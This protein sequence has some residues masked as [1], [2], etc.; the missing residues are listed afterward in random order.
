MNEPQYNSQQNHI[1]NSDPFYEFDSKSSNLV[2]ELESIQQ[3]LAENPPL[4]RGDNSNDSILKK[5]RF[6]FI[7]LMC[8]SAIALFIA[9]FQILVSVPPVHFPLEAPKPSP[10]AP[11][12]IPAARPRT[13]EEVDHAI[14]TL[15]NYVNQAKWASEETAKKSLNDVKS[16]LE[17]QAKAAN[18]IRL[19]TIFSSGLF[20]IALA[21]GA[22][23]VRISQNPNQSAIDK[24]EIDQIKIA[25]ENSILKFIDLVKLFQ[26]IY[27]TAYSNKK[28]S[29]NQIET[30]KS[31]FDLLNSQTELIAKGNDSFSKDAVI[32]YVQTSSETIQSQIADLERK[33]NECL[34]KMTEIDGQLANT[35][36]LINSFSSNLDRFTREIVNA[37]PQAEPLDYDYVKTRL[38][39]LREDIN[40]FDE[41]PRLKSNAENALSLLHDA[42]K[43]IGALDEK[44]ISQILVPFNLS[45]Y[46]L[47]IEKWSKAGKIAQELEVLR[48]STIANLKRKFEKQ[49]RIIDPE[50]STF[51]DAVEHRTDYFIDGPPEKVGLIAFTTSPGFWLGE[52]V[53]PAAVVLYKTEQSGGIDETKGVFKPDHGSALQENKPA[54]KGQDIG[55]IEEKRE[56]KTPEATGSNSTTKN[57]STEQTS[58]WGNGQKGN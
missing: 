11:T 46:R 32:G 27:K 40:I 22:W 35:F 8:L 5:G 25:Q 42:N 48:V 18:N 13:P 16:K 4:S 33:A 43:E 45:I 2:R 21:L 52:T 19:A 30:L 17:E 58:K 14:S 44:L 50:P 1:E 57:P 7:V 39:E 10:N 20:L 3:K 37:D 38:A 49:L 55:K 54:I 41:S 31:Q 56:D 24:M 53:R 36:S 34:T 15:K 12:E 6:A 26:D 47:K 51:P 23:I 9:I 28:V 29:D